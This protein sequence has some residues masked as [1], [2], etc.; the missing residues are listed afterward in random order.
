MLSNKYFIF[1]IFALLILVAAYNV[2]FFTSKKAV[3]TRVQ[4]AASQQPSAALSDKI[5]VTERNV[6]SKDS[7][8]WMRDP[9]SVEKTETKSEI[10]V[11]GIIKKNG[12]SRAL[13]N[14]RVYSTNDAIGSSVIK[15]I[16]RDSVV[17]STNGIIKEI[18]LS[19]QSAIKET[20]K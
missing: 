2:K 3:Q 8:K 12:K 4:K 16:K 7:S 17:I 18:F 19:N 9:F 15:D 6:I 5:I 20:T 13:I 1:A 11:S 14:G 10:T